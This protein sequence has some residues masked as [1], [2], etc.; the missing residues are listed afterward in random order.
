MSNGR[1]NEVVL[2]SC[3]YVL[4]TLGYIRMCASVIQPHLIGHWT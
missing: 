2:H 1:S 3:I 4:R